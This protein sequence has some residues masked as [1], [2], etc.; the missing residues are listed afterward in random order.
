M[1]PK[2]VQTYV[3]QKI[4]IC[5]HYWLLL[6]RALLEHDHLNHMQTSRSPSGIRRKNRVQPSRSPGLMQCLSF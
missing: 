1:S 6:S 3:P 5:R 4:S 2:V